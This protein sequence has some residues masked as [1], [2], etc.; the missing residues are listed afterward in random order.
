[1][2]I[3]A[4]VFI[5][6]PEALNPEKRFPPSQSASAS[7]YLH[8]SWTSL[9]PDKRA[10]IT[11]SRSVRA[12]FISSSWPAWSSPDDDERARKG[13]FG[14]CKSADDSSAHR[15]FVD[16]LW[17]SLESPSDRW[18][19]RYCCVMFQTLSAA[20]RVVTSVR[21]EVNVLKKLK[22]LLLPSVKVCSRDHAGL[23]HSAAGAQLLHPHL[24]WRFHLGSTSAASSAAR[25][26]PI[27][28]WT[29][30][31]SLYIERSFHL[32]VIR[33]APVHTVG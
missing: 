21:H 11:P 15:S 3:K 4:S 30:P 20:T 22:Q 29:Q 33:T 25:L 6:N 5:K 28:M 24:D 12:S 18:R 27:N 2:Q 9:I 1:M 16:S 17:S 19:Q 8:T 10:E 14:G 31:P 7:L 26:S 32:S 23:W 13:L